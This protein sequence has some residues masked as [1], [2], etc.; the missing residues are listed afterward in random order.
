MKGDVMETYEIST[1]NVNFDS[2]HV[3]Q[4]YLIDIYINKKEQHG[5]DRLELYIKD[6]KIMHGMV[7]ILTHI[8][9]EEDLNRIEFYT[10]EDLA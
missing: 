6:E 10:K 9:S 1:F 2:E 3:N 5:C 4:G 7:D 8:S